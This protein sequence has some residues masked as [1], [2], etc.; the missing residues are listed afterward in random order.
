M[1]ITKLK[2][3]LLMFLSLSMTNIYSQKK[4]DN[5]TKYKRIKKLRKK[6]KFNFS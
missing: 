6:Y 4:L 3:V 2:L 1:S 5:K